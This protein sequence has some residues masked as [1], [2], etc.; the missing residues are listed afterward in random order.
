MQTLTQAPARHP[1]CGEAV[2]ATTPLRRS[3]GS[4]E[5]FFL[6]SALLGLML[7]AAPARAAASGPVAFEF[8]VPAL[9]GVRNP[10][11][12]E[13]WAEVVTP[14]GHTLVLPAYYSG[15]DTFV[16]H[17]RPAETGAYRFGRAAEST[18]G[19]RR[20]DVAVTLVSP[21][22]V[23]NASPL[24]LPA[25]GRD[26][27]N[28]HGFARADGHAFYPA[29][30]NL[31]WA[32]DAPCVDFYR[33]AL[34]AFARANLNWMRVWMSSWGQLDLD[35]IPPELG[36]S[37]PPGGLDPRVA[38][39]WDRIIAAAQSSGVYLQMVLQYHGQ[40]STAVNPAWKENP[41][42][43]ANPGG[44]LQ[45][46]VDFFT[47]SEA[48][49]ITRLKYR[50]IV[51]RWGWS[52]AI[53]AWEFFNEV[54]WTDAMR[55]GHEADVARWHAEMAD[56]VRS[57]DA[58]GHL[59]T[60]S[61]DDLHSPVYAKMDFYQPHLYAADLVAATRRFMLPARGLDR[62]VFYGE[63]GDDHLP[64]TPAAKA[65]GL[66][67]IPPVWAS[68]LG[69]GRFPAMQWDGWKLLRD[70]RLDELGAVVRFVVLN[71][72]P[73]HPGL[74]P[75]SP[76]VESKTTVS[77]ALP[78]SQVWQRRRQAPELTLSTD[79]R[80]SPDLAEMP[81]V[82]AAPATQAGPAFPDHVT[83]HLTFPQAATVRVTAGAVGEHGATLRVTLDGAVVAEKSWPAGRAEGA[84]QDELAF[85]VTAG[86][87]TLVLANPRGPDW[88]A[89]PSVDLGLPVSALAA[90]GRRDDRLIALWLWRRDRLYTP[91][92]GA[93]VAGTVTIDAVPAGDWRITWWDTAKGAPAGAPEARHHAGGPLRLAT[94]PITRH[95]AVALQRIGD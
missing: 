11:A 14:S 86:P 23:E 6:R 68:V 36:A 92:P 53:F 5:A 52:T 25:V 63:V 74:R 81:A 57:I 37:P 20:Q 77:L 85:A 61:T 93:P 7:A 16:I 55:Q 87:H 58:Y 39:N 33:A 19:V 1:G 9:E 28:P 24:R 75:F 31:A 18:A 76:L 13:L 27:K 84:A 21:A 60:T 47:S 46:P 64:A 72:L 51:A 90:I 56:F 69:E 41:W 15:H 70:H 65:A 40:Y 32:Q 42:N 89:V 82:L 67:L 44:F 3:T 29:G 48:R 26:P 91:E 80:E 83:C 8:K 49:L 88:V 94:P 59:L 71:H 54:H 35:W 45:S 22:T 10:Y 38:E 4:I 43:A 30:A 62:P 17:A 95:A 50:Y 66:T 2:S 79:G 73:N 78:A 12:R 34:P